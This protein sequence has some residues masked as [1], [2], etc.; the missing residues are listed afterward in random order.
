MKRVEFAALCG[1]TPQMITK[2]A[3]D[4]FIVFVDRKNVDAR[5]S[6]ALLEGRLDAAK[7]SA[8]HAELDSRDAAAAQTPALAAPV[9]PAPPREAPARNAKVELDELKRDQAALD[10]ARAAGLLVPIADV[11]RRAWEALAAMRSAYDLARTETAE[12]LCRDLAIPPE[13]VGAM[14]RT[15]QRLQARALAAFQQSMQL[16]GEQ[17]DAVNDDAPAEQVRESA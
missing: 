11:E 10:L 15:L 7:H 8:A 12:Q 14:N 17:D 1:V 4:G 16:R 3:D 5:A 2:Y 9:A 6:L 13:R